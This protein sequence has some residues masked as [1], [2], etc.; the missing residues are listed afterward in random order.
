LSSSTEQFKVA[1][2]GRPHGLDGHLGLYVDPPDLIH[3]EPGSV[4]LVGDREL[5]VRSVRPSDR[6]HQVA[7]SEV[8]DRA[9]AEEIR[10]SDVFVAGRRQLEE[11]EFWPSDLVGLEVRPGGGKVIGLEHGPGQD[12]LV[13]ERGSVSFEVPFVVALVPV[14]DLEGGYLEIVELEGLT[15]PLSE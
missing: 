15:P 11:G 12:R 7:F 3:F 8:P 5:T 6:G 9:S 2:L 1:R 4:V 14:V 10:N 13:I